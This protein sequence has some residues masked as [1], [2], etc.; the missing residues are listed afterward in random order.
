MEY[1]SRSSR[2]KGPPNR[3][4]KEGNFPII[5][6]IV[7]VTIAT[8]IVLGIYSLLPHEEFARVD[9]I[10]WS[11]DVYLHQ[12]TI[13]H[14][15]EWGEPWGKDVVAG[16]TNCYRKY[17]GQESCFCHDS[18]SGTGNNRSCHRVCSSCPEYRTWCDYDHYTWPVVKQ[19]NKS[20]TD[21]KCEWPE[22]EE[23][24]E[25]QRIS[26]KETY[27]VFFV[28]KKTEKKYTYNVSNLTEFKKFQRGDTWLIKEYITGNAEPVRERK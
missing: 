12:R 4:I 19:W 11:Y 13:T 24:K 25:N 3:Y 17:Y 20:S 16:T 26:K 23:A 10:L 22:Y 7:A 15:G 5:Q 21:H 18:C 8:L 6:A 9:R 2:S 14:G 27:N 1:T 28:D